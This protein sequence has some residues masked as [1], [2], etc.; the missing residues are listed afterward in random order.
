MFHPGFSPAESKI[1]NGASGVWRDAVCRHS[2]LK[3][4]L[5]QKEGFLV[6]FPQRKTRLQ[7]SLL[8]HK[9]LEFGLLILEIG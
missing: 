2:L 9:Q 3:T 1:L 7:S 6:F 5:L 8:L 4:A